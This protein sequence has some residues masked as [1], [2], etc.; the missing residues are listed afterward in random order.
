MG[1]VVKNHIVQNSKPNKNNV[2]IFDFAIRST[3]AGIIACQIYKLDLTKID[4]AKF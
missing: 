1:V 2:P 4:Y 3:L